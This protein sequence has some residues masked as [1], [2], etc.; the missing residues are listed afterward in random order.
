MAYLESLV[1]RTPFLRAYFTWIEK[2]YPPLPSLYVDT[3]I[4]FPSFMIPWK[5]WV[6]IPPPIMPPP[7]MPPPIPPPV[8][9]TVIT[10]V[11]PFIAIVICVGV[12]TPVLPIIWENVVFPLEST[13]ECPKVQSREP[14]LPEDTECITQSPIMSAVV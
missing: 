2:G 5:V 7:I 3:I 11:A 10:P 1:P 9:G 12:I 13:N 14:A 6:I 8:P 4:F